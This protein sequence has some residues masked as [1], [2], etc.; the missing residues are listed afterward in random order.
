MNRYI[1]SAVAAL[2]AI[3]I[4]ISGYLPIVAVGQPSKYDS[5]YNSGT[6]DVVC[7]TLDG[8]GAD[9]YY[10]GSNEYDVLSQ[11]SANEI[12]SALTSLMRTTH[13]YISSYD[14]CHYKADR[15]D[16]EN[17]DKRV[18]LIYTS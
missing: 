16:C 15:T 7:T 17:G 4:I 6:R 5:S 8:T 12:K 11:K 10:T 2:L 1:K 14:D 3:V 13:S 18:S 9:A